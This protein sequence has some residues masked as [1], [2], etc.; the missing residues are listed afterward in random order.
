MS[1]NGVTE[2]AEKLMV[3]AEKLQGVILADVRV[4]HN[5]LLY[6]RLRDGTVDT[7]SPGVDRG[8]SVRVFV[9]G[10]YGF[11][12]TTRLDL[13]SLRKALHEAYS[14]ARAMAASPKRMN[15]RPYLLDALEAEHVWPVSRDP[16][17]VSIEEKVKDLM[18][19]DRTLTNLLKSIKSRDII[20]RELTSVK[21]YV[22]TEGRKIR[23]EKNIT[24]LG[25]VA[26]AREG[27]VMAEAIER[28]GTTRGYALWSKKSIEDIAKTVASRLE[29]QLRAKTPKAGNYPVVIAPEV[30]GVFVHEAFGHLTEADLT[31]AGSV[32]KGKLG[33]KVASEHV[34]IVDDPTLDDGFGTFKFDDEGV[35]AARAVLVEKGILKQLMVDRVYAS[36]LGTDPTGN[37]RAESFRVPPLIRMRNTVMLP[38]DHSVEELFEGIKF[39]YYLVSHLGGQA[40]TDGN[41]QVGVQEAYEIVNGEIG[42]PVRGLSISG[43][44]LETLM[45]IDAVGKDF[46][47]HYGMC[48]KVQMV[49]VSDG[50][51]HV[52]VKSVAVGGRAI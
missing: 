19:L 43:N 16:R 34:S 38:G 26:T 37:A 4:E 10:G 20:Y 18:E 25:V 9:D 24:Y 48:G 8:A 30:L 40:N 11:A 6:I 31:L 35:S 33:Q 15:V 21:I 7:I 13:E 46:E 22:S 17:D 27:D 49:Y 39:G 14:M 2:I 42:E 3:E 52:R 51:P 32:V 50:G 1:L 5:D 29:K 28:V 45:N 44:T 36:I 41:F 12:Y 23:E 47:L